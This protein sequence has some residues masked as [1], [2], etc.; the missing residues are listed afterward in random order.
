MQ[1]PQF[2]SVPD[3][4]TG[5]YFALQVIVYLAINNFTLNNYIK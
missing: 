3:D 1:T 2:S 4:L 5:V